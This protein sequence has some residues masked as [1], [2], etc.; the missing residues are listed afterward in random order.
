VVA[1]LT[2]LP[3]TALL[4]HLHYDH[5]GNFH[6]FA[7]RALPDLPL[8]RAFDKE[9]VF[10]APEDMFFGNHENMIWEPV[11]IR[12]WW[13]DRPSHRSRRQLARNHRDAWPFT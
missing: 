13:A 7:D 2:K 12:Q 11:A 5:T 1:S 10:M 8:L 9:G 4:S 6:R 3:V